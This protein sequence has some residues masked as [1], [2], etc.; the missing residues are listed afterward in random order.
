MDRA[1]LIGV[2]KIPGAIQ[3]DYRPIS[4]RHVSS[5]ARSEQ[6]CEIRSCGANGLASSS[7]ARAKRNHSSSAAVKAASKLASDLSKVVFSVALR[8]VAQNS[9][10][11]DDRGGF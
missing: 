9:A 6:R 3:W 11:S 5:M 2:S 4:K 1:G 10:S 7:S 8:G